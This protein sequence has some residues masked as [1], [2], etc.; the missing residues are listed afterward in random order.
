M[1]LGT[2]ENCGSELDATATPQTISSPGWPHN[3][4]NNVYCKWIISA[5]P[6]Y[7]VKLDIPQVDTEP[8]CDEF[9]VSLKLYIYT[10]VIK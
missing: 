2:Y 6:G 7:Q 3:Y 5:P 1:F 4:T 10:I 8:C 9:S